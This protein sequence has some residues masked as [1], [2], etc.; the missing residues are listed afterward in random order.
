VLPPPGAYLSLQKMKLDPRSKPQFGQRVP[1]VVAYGNPGDRLIDQV[2]TPGFLLGHPDTRLNA[3]Y[4]ITKQIIPALNRLFTLFGVDVNLWYQEMTRPRVGVAIH[5][6]SQLEKTHRTT[7]DRFSFNSKCVGCG[8]PIEVQP[9]TS[10]DKVTQI[11]L[12]CLQDPPTVLGK[13]LLRLKEAQQKYMYFHTKCLN[14]TGITWEREVSC[15]SLA[16][17]IYFDR[18]RARNRYSQQNVISKRFESFSW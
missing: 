10:P 15:E 17:A 3:N 6:N 18:I 7:L 8:R 14:C 16:C 9:L 2:C 11:C 4:Y 5:S 12:V 1:Y 13:V